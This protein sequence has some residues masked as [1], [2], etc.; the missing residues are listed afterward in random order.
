MPPEVVDGGISDTPR[1]HEKSD[2][3]PGKHWWPHGPEGGSEPVMVGDALADQDEEFGV[4]PG[5]GNY[6]TPPATEYTIL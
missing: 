4:A 3:P 6:D 1:G 5:M 2:G